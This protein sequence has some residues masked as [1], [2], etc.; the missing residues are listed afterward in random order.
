[1]MKYYDVMLGKV[2]M[3]STP[4]IDEA[5]DYAA[6]KVAKGKKPLVVPKIRK[7]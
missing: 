7:I 4:F 5:H 2:I 1:M 3:I 6:K